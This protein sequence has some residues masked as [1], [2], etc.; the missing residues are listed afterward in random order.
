MKLWGFDGS[1]EVNSDFN[2]RYITMV[3]WLDNGGFMNAGNGITGFNRTE[4]GGALNVDTGWGFM[5]EMGHNFDTAG[6]TI[7]EVTNNIL[8]LHFQ[9]IKGERSKISAQNLWES[10]I[11]PTSKESRVSVVKYLNRIY[12]KVEYSLKLVKRII[13]TMNG[14]QTMT[15]VY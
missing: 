2:F 15:V 3:K 4:Q 7:V 13:L 6:R 12:G 10:R 1:S 9:R 8:P 5:H 11:F 14:I